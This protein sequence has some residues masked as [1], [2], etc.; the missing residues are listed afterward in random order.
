MLHTLSFIS[1][2]WLQTFLSSPKQLLF[3]YLYYASLLNTFITPHRWIRVLLFT[4]EHIYNCSSL[5]TA[6]YV[7]NASSLNTS[8]TLHHWLHVQRFIVSPFLSSTI[9]PFSS[10][11]LLVGSVGPWGWVFGLIACQSPSPG[12]ALPIF[13]NNNNNYAWS[14][15]TCI[16]PHRWICVLHLISEYLHVLRLIAELSRSSEFHL[17]ST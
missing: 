7:Y 8:I 5:F 14:L 15:N 10:F 12:L 11:P 17:N 3:E 1:K 9:F 6:E 13:F 4:A 2:L 16:T